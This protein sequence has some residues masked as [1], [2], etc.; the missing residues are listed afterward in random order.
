[1]SVTRRRLLA[2][3]ASTPIAA[4][5]PPARSQPAAPAPAPSLRAIAPAPVGTCIQTTHIQDLAFISLLRA[6]FSQVTPEWEMKMERIVRDDG[7]FDFSAADAIAGFARDNGLRLYG[8]TLIWYAQRP[9]AFEH[10]DEG[11]RSFADAYRNYILAV[12]GRYR[13]QAVGWDVVNEPV[14]EDG[15][16][17]RESLWASRLGA[18]DYMM[19]AFDHAHEADPD[20]M[21]FINDYN[22]ESRPAKRATF[23]RLIERLLRRGAKIG[24]VGNQ[25][26][27]DIDLPAGAAATAMRELASFGLPVH[28]SELDVSLGRN[29]LDLRPRSEKLRVQ[30]RK[31]AEVAEAFAALPARQRFAFTV[32]GLRDRDSWLRSPPN[33]GDGT[34]AP[35]L[36][37]DAG[38]PK[39]AFAAVAQV[40]QRLHQS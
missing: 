25:S 19:R 33:A 9:A 26:H 35:L 30:A 8:T 7:S 21:L 4:C 5:Q 17:L 2:A 11:R 38:R 22:L 20:A 34:D 18:D 40:F 23:M 24:G 10:L 37:D 6:Q 31:A 27:I 39:P 3:A 15:F 32:W 36:F 12:A 29:P 1:M 13:G 28:V 14:N 16:G